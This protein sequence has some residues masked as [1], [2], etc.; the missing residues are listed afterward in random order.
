MTLINHA[1]LAMFSFLIIG[2]V[3]AQDMSS[4]QLSKQWTL[5]KEEGDIQLYVRKDE[6]KMGSLEKPFSYT[7]I[8]IVNNGT[9]DHTVNF[10]LAVHFENECIGCISNPE[11]TKHIKISAN[12]SLETDCSFENGALAVLIQNPN[13]GDKRIFTGLELKNFKL[14]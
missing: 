1:I 2:N 11:T 12:S 5:L 4:S 6:C 3:N 9:T 10:D 7:F 14:N 13:F 8:K